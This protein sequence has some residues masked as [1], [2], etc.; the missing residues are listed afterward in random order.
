M[1]I[2]DY[3]TEQ[4]TMGRRRAKQ[5]GVNYGVLRL[6]ERSG[7]DLTSAEH[8]NAYLDG[9]RSDGIIPVVIEPLPN[10][11]YDTVKCGLP[12]RDEA[13]YKLK[14]IVALMGRFHIPTLCLN[15]MAHVGWYRS[16]QNYPLRGGALGTAFDI[17]D[18][19]PADDFA[20]TQEQIWA[21]MESFFREIV[22][23]AEKYQ[24]RLALH[25]DDPPVPAL[26]NVGRVLTSLQSIDRAVHLVDSPMLG[27]TLCQ[28]CY[29]AMGEDVDLAI[30][31]FAAQNKLF[32]VHFR[33][34]RGTRECFHETFH[35]DGQTDMAQSVYTY[36][37]VGFVGP[38][39]VDHVPTLAG[40]ENVLP[41]YAQMGRLYAIGYLRGLLE[42]AQ[43]QKSSVN[44][45]C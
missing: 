4:D 45:K 21:N 19:V 40:E 42:A 30:R 29:S 6:P 32:F 43:K 7:F 18:Y 37:E 35:D 38:A 34:V 41:G 1:Q 11:L 24:V 5:V 25:P 31:H 13:M 9:F 27:V 33:D 23:V 36:L 28:G 12:G 14:R 22:P 44:M 26:G 3:F 8:W 16:R 15:F 10:G 2:A 20:I 17:K 39:R